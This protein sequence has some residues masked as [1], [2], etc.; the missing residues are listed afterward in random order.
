MNEVQAD[1]PTYGPLFWTG[2]LVGW[3]VM[4]F[5][6]VGISNSVWLKDRP[7]ELAVWVLGGLVVH[8]ALLASSVTIIGLLLARLLPRWLRGP[9]AGAVALS[10]LVLLF[11]YPLLRGFG[12]RESNRSI[13]PLD[14][15]RNVAIVLALIWLAAAAVVVARL[16]RRGRA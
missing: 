2:L 9:V 8:D 7:V 6:V 1:R 4:G 5:A 15:D 12:R 16:V 3:S 11:S 10:G 14:Y 13:L